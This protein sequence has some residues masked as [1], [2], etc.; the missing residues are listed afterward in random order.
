MSKSKKLINSNPKASFESTKYQVVQAPQL[1]VNDSSAI[2]IE[3]SKED[4]VE[5]EKGDLLCIIETTKATLEVFSPSSGFLIKLVKE[6]EE[7]IV[8]QE[9]AVISFD[10]EKISQIFSKF[11]NEQKNNNSELAI[12]KKAL[13]LANRYDINLDHL[14]TNNTLIRVKDIEEIIDKKIPK[15]KELQIDKDKTSVAIYGAGKG[16]GTIY[17]TLSLATKYKVAAF[18]D[19]NLVGS[20][21][22]IPI[23]RKDK[24][25]FLFDQGVEHIIIAIANC[26]QRL[27][28]GK[29]LEKEGFSFINAVHPNAFI[30]PSCKLGKGN[31]IKAGSIIETNTIIGDHNII[32]NGVVIAH[33]NVIGNGCHLAPNSTLGSSIKI[34]DYSILGIGSSISTKIKIGKGCIIALNT[35]VLNN[36]ENNSLVEGVPGRIVGKTNIK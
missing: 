18:I 14:K 29:D 28:L 11:Q 32:D 21:L 2:L 35:S 1:G 17:E 20:F 6:N 16:G 24:I 7:I 31:H 4:D 3:W 33:E 8:N 23:F 30:S 34:G 19:D 13:D 27:T 26:K 9:I 5:I 22:D 10:K 36:I 15:N 12:T 25:K